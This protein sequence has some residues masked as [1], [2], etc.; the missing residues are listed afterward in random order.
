MLVQGPVRVP[1][2]VTGVTMWGRMCYHVVMDVLPVSVE[3]MMN[4]QVK[5]KAFMT[6]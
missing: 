5:T 4:L 1:C 2:A 6:A 3:V